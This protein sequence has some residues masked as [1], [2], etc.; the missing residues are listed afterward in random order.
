MKTV[1]VFALLWFVSGLAWGSLPE[2][3]T[4]AGQSE[5]KDGWLIAAAPAK[6]TVPLGGDTMTQVTLRCGA[7]DRKVTC[8]AA[9]AAGA[10]LHLELT[11]RDDEYRVGIIGKEVIPL[12]DSCLEL[13]LNQPGNEIFRDRYYV[14]PYP[15]WYEG[16]DRKRVLAGWAQLPP[17]STHE[18]ELGLETRGTL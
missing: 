8:D 3:W 13:R 6:L 5:E 10:P 14:R 4:L 17:A 16:A 11:A 7:I 15:H 9:G 18:V 12:P 2:N 1:S